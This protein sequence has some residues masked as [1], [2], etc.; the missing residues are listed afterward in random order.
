MIPSKVGIV[1]CGNICGIY[2]Q[3]GKTFDILDIVACTDILMD[4]ADSKSQECGCK[5]YTVDDFYDDPDIDI[6]INITPPKAHAEVALKA[7]EAGKSVYNEKPL[8]ITREDARKMLDLAKAKGLRVG[9]A[10]DTFLGGGIQTCI[11]LIDDGW[12]GEPIGAT[13]FCAGHGC[14]SW[15]PDPE[16]FYKIGAGPVFDM[17]PYYITA[18]VSMMGP[19]KRATGSTRISFP[20]RVITSQPHFGEIIEVE[21]PTHV[22]GILEFGNGAIGTLITSFDIWAAELPRI[23]IYGT[24]GTISVPDPN[25]FGGPVRI[26][27]A[28]ASEWSE[29]PLSHGYSQNSRG[30]GTADMAHALRSGR[31]H[32][33]SG[34][35][36]FHVLDIMHAVHESSDQGRHIELQSTC[37]RPKP[38]PMGLRHGL[39]DE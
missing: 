19:V 25:T 20:K 33:A 4:R 14:E 21:V 23:E 3:A 5:A 34:E 31:A 9:C 11:K 28:G 32:R 39:L 12:I 10:P 6:V 30:L 2:F 24:L 35:L 7:L 22:T 27:R 16:F 29:I 18:L 1:G 36:A 26:R 13:A 15:H 37:A 38:L 8:A 17:G